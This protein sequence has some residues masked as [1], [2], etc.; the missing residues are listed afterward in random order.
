M[1]TPCSDPISHSAYIHCMASL[2]IPPLD[3]Q[4]EIL[5]AKEK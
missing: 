1:I 2:S 5:T 4:D 3:F